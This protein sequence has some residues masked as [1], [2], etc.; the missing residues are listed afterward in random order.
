M[1]RRTV[2]NFVGVASIIFAVVPLCYI[3]RP[4]VFPYHAL[5]EYVVLIGGVGGAFLG[6]TIAGLLGS[7]WWL[8]AILGAAVDAVCLFGFSP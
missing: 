5:T 6:A 4:D 8:L 3:A 7:R 2:A 1:N